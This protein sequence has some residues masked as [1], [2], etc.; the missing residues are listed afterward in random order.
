[1]HGTLVSGS[2]T[3]RA[4]G[5][6]VAIL[7]LAALLRLSALAKPLYIDEIVSITVAVQPLAEMAGVMRQIDASPA[8]YPVLLHAWLSLADADVWARLLS[9]LAGILTVLVVWLIGRRYFSERA[10]L[11]AAGIAAIAPAHVHYSQ[12]VRS[13]AFL[14]LFATLY[15]WC[16]LDWFSERGRRPAIPWWTVTL[17]AVGLIY[18]HYLALLVFVATTAV[19]VLHWRRSPCV[20]ARWAGAHVLA[21]VLFL[22]GL[23][24]FLHNLE[25]DRVR[26]VQRG[27]PPS[28]H[29]L[30]PN[31]I[32]EL[33]LGQRALGFD[34]PTVRRTVF[35]AAAVLFP[36][37]FLVG[38]RAGFRE[39]PY[40]TLLAAAFFWLPVLLY[41]L[42]GRRLVAVRF[43]VPFLA[44]YFLVLGQGLATLKPR[45]QVAG[46]AALALVSFV[47]LAHF[48]SSYSWS[49][50]HRTVAR[51]IAER[52]TPG[53]RLLVVH[54]Y[55]A[56]YYRRYLGPSTPITG[57]VFTA[58]E[59]QPGYVIKPRDLDVE[60]AKPIVRKA[61]RHSHNLWVIGQSTRS[62]AS[63]AGQQAALLEWM[64]TELG[65]GAVFDDLTGGDPAIRLYAGAAPPDES[66][67][68]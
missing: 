12:Y 52:L 62:F 18:T 10:G 3:R 56:F 51:A 27:E 31:L 46:A 49:Y 47:P 35:A 59:N 28:P 64:D 33:S 39:R 7:V 8:L 53:D 19:A 5:W 43:F 29:V 9:A 15:L 34:D 55:E 1:M 41:V 50:D 17:A 36:A 38:L 2:D 54:P 13:Y 65:P 21:A 6:L 30:L 58:L 66:A 45:A 23:P 24:L 11:Y 63:D 25:T 60:L 67:E 22:P 26:D 20:V 44:G 32:A 4:A 37:L 42:A 57:L 68:R 61:A 48:Y 14:G 16:A 40:A